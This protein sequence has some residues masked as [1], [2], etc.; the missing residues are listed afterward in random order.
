MPIYRDD[1][2]GWMR[3]VGGP[4][5]GTLFLQA[6][7][8]TTGKMEL[9]LANWTEALEA[10]L[11]GIVMRGKVKG[12]KLNIVLWYLCQKKTDRIQRSVKITSIPNGGLQWLNIQL[13]LIRVQPV[14]GL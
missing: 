7:L 3:A 1:V 13:R 4:L 10:A 2:L 11:S 14:P 6:G 8:K 9:S 12:C 5:Y